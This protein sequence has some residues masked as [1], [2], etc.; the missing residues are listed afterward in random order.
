MSCSN[1]PESE[2]SYNFV[3]LMKIVAAEPEDKHFDSP[4]SHRHSL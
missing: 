1:F 3:G 2:H 4:W